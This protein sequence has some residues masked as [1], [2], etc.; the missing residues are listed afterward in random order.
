MAHHLFATKIEKDVET[1]LRTFQQKKEMQNIQNVQGNL[2]NMARELEDAREKSEKLSKKGAKASTHK[3]DLAAS[4]LDSAIQQ[5][6]SQAPFIFESLQALDETRMNQIRDALT[7][8]GTYAGEH[9]QQLQAD[10]EGVLNGLLDYQTSSEI[11]HF[12][13]KTTGGRPKIEKRAPTAGAP[14]A[15]PPARQSSSTGGASTNAVQTPSLNALTPTTEDARSEYSVA[16]DGPS[17]NKLRSRIGTMLGRRR[18]SI[19]GGF[20]Q[21]SP[22]KGPFGRN[23][24]SSHGPS[25]RA[26]STNLA[27]STHRLGSLVERPDTDNPPRASTATG[28]LSR[29]DANGTNGDGTTDA[30]P[31]TSSSSRVNGTS[32]ATDVFD[33]PPPPG[34]PPSHQKEPEK[35]S[36]GFSVPTASHDPISEAQ[37]EAGIEEAEQLFKLNIS[38]EPVAEEDPEEKKAALSSVANSLAAG[39]P[40]RKS[41]TV[42][43]RRDVRNTIYVPAPVSENPL[44]GNPFPPSPALPTSASKSSG[45]ANMVSE[46]SVA[47]TSDTQSIRSAT[48]LGSVAHT[49]HPEMHEPGLQS[50]VIETVSATFE[51]GQVK[52]VNVNG[53]IAFAYNSNDITPF[54]SGTRSLSYTISVSV[55]H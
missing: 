25:P 30:P 13:S 33:V 16:R 37:K 19:H 31:K 38:K 8:Y 51:G 14:P 55:F 29:E 22:A 5:W 3:V 24:K 20:G 50:S 18:Q 36:E 49:K 42:R 34:P 6:E 9:A 48:S 12:V 47:G 53:E 52:S 46:P 32:T 28:R 41:G 23:A 4:R 45:V 17:E 26:S 11:H 2:H 39:M 10:A 54:S 27:D 7:Q 35:D 15:P 21:L 40:T 44:P 43:G 1:P